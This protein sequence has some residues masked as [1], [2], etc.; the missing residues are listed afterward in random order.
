M[1]PAVWRGS[2]GLLP[3]GPEISYGPFVFDVVHLL[4]GIHGHVGLLAVA[5]LIHPVFTLRGARVSRGARW[6]AWGATTLAIGAFA[7]GW[8]LYPGYRSGTKR[9]LLH[10]APH[11]AQ[12]F[13]V[14]EHL[15]FYAVVLSI[16]GAGLVVGVPNRGG[17][18]AA[19]WCYGL[20]GA[21]ALAVVALGTTVG[22]WR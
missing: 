3:D 2:D 16:A 18:R 6:G 13:E 21:L 4:R 15:A 17:L 12:A 11:L 19:R 8:A 20:G 7:A 1:R 14:K 10:A 9:E 5:A 22:A